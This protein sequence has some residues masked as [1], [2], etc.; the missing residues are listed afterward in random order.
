MVNGLMNHQPLLHKYVILK[1]NMKTA[2]GTLWKKGTKLFVGVQD[3]QR[4]ALYRN[5][6]LAI[7]NAQVSDVEVILE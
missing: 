6:K 3:N 1:R 4:L 5:H 7:C 2:G